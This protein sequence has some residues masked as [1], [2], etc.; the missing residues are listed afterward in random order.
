MGYL[1]L[2]FIICIFCDITR[3]FTYVINNSQINQMIEIYIKWELCSLNVL[4][5]T[6]KWIAGVFGKTS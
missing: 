1:S 3:F 4:A 5:E 6:F 2:F